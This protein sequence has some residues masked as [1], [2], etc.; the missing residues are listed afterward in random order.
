MAHRI[1]PACSAVRRSRGPAAPVRR[2]PLQPDSLFVESM[3]QPASDEM[4][5]E[6]PVFSGP[7]RLLAELI[8]DQKVDVCDVPVARVTERFLRRGREETAGW[9]L[10]EAT[11]FLA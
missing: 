2:R 6:L 1:E 8:F 7:F 3:S 11:W 9:T 4:L 5:V 10:E